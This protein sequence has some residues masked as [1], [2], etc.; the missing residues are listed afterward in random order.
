MEVARV[1]ALPVAHGVA[2]PSP[3][4]TRPMVA[5]RERPIVAG[6]VAFPMPR[7]ATGAPKARRPPPARV[8]GQEGPPPTRAVPLRPRPT[9]APWPVRPW[10][11]WP[12]RP[13]LA[14]V[15]RPRVPRALGLGVGPCRALRPARAPIGEVAVVIDLE[16][17]TF[18]TTADA[19]ATAFEVNASN[20]TAAASIGAAARAVGQ[21]GLVAETA[22]TVAPE[23]KALPATGPRAAA[24]LAPAISVAPPP[25]AFVVNAPPKGRAAAPPGAEVEARGATMDGPTAK[26]AAAG[27]ASSPGRAVMEEA[28]PEGPAPTTVVEEEAG[29]EPIAGA[30]TMATPALPVVAPP[31]AIVDDATAKELEARPVAPHEEALRVAMRGGPTDLTAAAAMGPAGGP[32]DS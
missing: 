2:S 16:P 5:L 31:G 32:G 18:V 11:P 22:V 10:V 24:D 13:R 20:P 12:I 17:T 9:P 7:A 25:R 28:R 21:G 3:V 26:V 15:V 30:A 4:T 29:K 1:P 6:P 8:A 27:A 23:T 14:R 19:R